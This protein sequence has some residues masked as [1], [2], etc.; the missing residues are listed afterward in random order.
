MHR[1]LALL[2]TLLILVACGATP[3]PSASES[4]SQRPAASPTELPSAATPASTPT[5]S[6]GP[7][8]PVHAGA[9]SI[10]EPYWLLFNGTSTSTVTG[11]DGTVLESS[12]GDTYQ[13]VSGGS[14]EGTILINGEMVGSLQVA[15]TEGQ[16]TPGL[17]PIEQQYGAQID[18]VLPGPEVPDRVPNPAWIRSEQRRAGLEVFIR[19]PATPSPE[20]IL[21]SAAFW[22]DAAHERWYQLTVTSEADF[23]PA[24]TALLGAKG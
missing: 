19:A 6:V 24:L 13:V 7:H 18:D 11:A 16:A 4:P 2:P 3:G 5:P 10:D 17:D 14:L 12:Q 9:P 23:E 8:R 1:R 20:V 21:P 22:W 15:L